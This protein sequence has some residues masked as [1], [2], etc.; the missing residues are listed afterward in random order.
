MELETGLNKYKQENGKNPECLSD[1][2]RSSYCSWAVVDREG[3]N[4]LMI[5][6][7]HGYAPFF[8][9]KGEDIAGDWSFIANQGKNKKW[10][11][12]VSQYQNESQMA[13]GDD[14][15]LRDSPEGWRVISEQP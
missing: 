11:V 1:I 13:V 2:S 3:N 6:C 8:Y 7:R 12:N 9:H 4:R 10:D 15:V 5:G 14:I